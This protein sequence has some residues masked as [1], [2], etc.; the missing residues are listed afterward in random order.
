MDRS[1]NY[2]LPCQFKKQNNSFLLCLSQILIL[3]WMFLFY[4]FVLLLLSTL[5]SPFTH[6]SSHLSLFPYTFCPESPLDKHHF[7]GILPSCAP[8]LLL[9]NWPPSTSSLLAMGTSMRGSFWTPEMFVSDLLP[10]KLLFHPPSYCLYYLYYCFFLPLFLKC[11]F[12]QRQTE[13]CA[14]TSWWSKR[15]LHAAED[16]AE[17]LL[18]HIPCVDKWQVV[19]LGRGSSRTLHIHTPPVCSA[20]ALGSRVQPPN[21]SAEATDDCSAAVFGPS[22]CT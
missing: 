15:G 2:I 14:E 16:R 19:L 9:C 13:C 4:V 8:I 10:K 7:W 1:V 21:S 5:L 20:S 11:S 18:P 17:E 22:A 3:Y 12:W 6:L